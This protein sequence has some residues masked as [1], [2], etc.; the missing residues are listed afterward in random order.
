MSDVDD[1]K[2]RLDIVEFIGGYLPLK[3]AG[4]N[5]R[6]T[7]PFH[8]EKTPSFMV[9]PEKQ[10]WHCFGCGKGGDIFGFL[11]ERE[12]LEFGEALAQLAQRAG[13]ELSGQRPDTGLKTKLFAINEWAAKFFE[14]ALTDSKEGRQAM[15]YLTEQRGISRETAKIFRVGYAPSGWEFLLK[16]MSKK[17][18][19]AADVER[20]GL[21]VKR[22]SQ[23]GDKFRSRLMFPIA[24]VGDRVVGF[25]GRVLD[26]TAAP[27]YLNS[28]ETPIFSKGQVIYGLSVAKS[29]IQEANQA[30][31]VEGQ[32]DVLASHQVGVKNVI[33]SSGT[34]LT[35]DQLKIIRRYAEVLVLALDADSAG[36]EATKRA[37]QLATEHE[38]EIRVALLG[39]F[40][41]PDEC[42]KA[43]V[44]KWRSAIAGAVP[45]I[46]FY[47]DHAVG[48]FGTDSVMAK[49]KVAATV[50]S[51]IGLL[52]N[53]VEV[54]QYVKKLSKVIGVDAP[55]LY[56]AMNMVKQP[57]LARSAQTRPEAKP[58]RDP[59]WL[60]KRVV[61]MLLSQPQRLEVL[62]GSLDK[63]K[64]SNAILSRVYAEFKNCYTGGD[65]LLD[66]LTSKLDYRDRVDLLELTMIADEQYADMPEADVEREITFYVQLLLQK[67]ARAAMAELSREVAA[68]EAAGDHDKLK[69]LLEQFK[70]F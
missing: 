5:Y 25:T 51:V 46:D 57:K 27:K 35:S 63:V 39:E 47:I 43:G 70:H 30:I 20:A 58:A 68:A 4:A 61:G 40:K 56:E 7:C 8:A 60:E 34:A 52:S 14:K 9:S 38:L 18:Y 50:L 41:D 62:R 64:W 3:K 23:L 36:G 16:F 69:S 13:V 31:L 49:K 65:F 22:G 28:P 59:D 26:P 33:A 21:A 24:N 6:S 1:I 55:K 44:D 19:T 17:G 12:G 66:T 10:I 15:N 54:D 11:M 53:P 32:M 67:S 48:K 29:A 2:A 42:I 37:I 45:V